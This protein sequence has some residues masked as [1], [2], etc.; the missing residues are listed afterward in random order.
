MS[1]KMEKKSEKPAEKNEET[2]DSEQPGLL[3][4]IRKIRA[5]DAKK[6][7]EKQKEALEEAL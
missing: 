6:Y 2:S 5:E 7:D 3:S 1:R 4:A